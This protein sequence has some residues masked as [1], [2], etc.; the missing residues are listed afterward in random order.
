MESWYTQ[1]IV[2][3]FSQNNCDLLD[4][5]GYPTPSEYIKKRHEEKGRVFKNKVSTRWQTHMIQRI[6]QDDVYIGNLRTRKMHSRLIKGKQEK[7]AK[8]EQLVF[9]N[10]HE[11]IISKQDFELAQSIKSKRSEAHYRVKPNCNNYIF[12]GFIKCGDC[13]RAVLGKNLKRKPRVQYGY[14]CGAYQK[15]G[16]KHCKSYSISKDKVLFFFKEFLKDVKNQ[17]EDYINN[18]DI[19]EKKRATKTSLDKMQKELNI[20]NDELK[21]LLNQ[22]IKDLLKETN[23]E[24]KQIIEN[25][26]N[27]LENEKKKRIN[28]LTQK[29]NKLR[30]ANHDNIENNLKA[31]ID[32]FDKIIKKERPDRKLLELILDKII[33]NSD[34]SL[35]FKLLVNIDKLIHADI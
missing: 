29:V 14:E 3:I 7:V 20:L 17:Y 9:E 16:L 21:L 18:V 5:N 35:E 6:I 25:S 10:H 13:G 15:Y 31:T 24:Y 32:I 28:E 8:E 2:N 34:R 22:K 33:L 4:E 26:Y 19:K 23:V 27:E 30:E 1:R 11:A 12:S